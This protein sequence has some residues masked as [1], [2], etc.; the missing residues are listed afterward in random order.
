MLWRSLWGDIKLYGAIKYTETWRAND[1][2]YP[3]S[4]I[5]VC[6]YFYFYLFFSIWYYLNFL[7]PTNIQCL[8]VT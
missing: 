5:N 8:E 7:Y 1:Y 2:L 3:Y 4:W 6:T